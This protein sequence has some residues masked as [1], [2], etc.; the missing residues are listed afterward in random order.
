[1]AFCNIMNTQIEHITHLQCTAIFYNLLEKSLHKGREPI[2][3]AALASQPAAGHSLSF[4]YYYCFMTL[5]WGLL[6]EPAAESCSRIWLPRLRGF[7]TPAISPNKSKKL[8]WLIAP[9]HNIRCQVWMKNSMHCFTDNNLLSVQHIM[10]I[11]FKLC[12]VYC[13]PAL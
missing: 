5:G 4:Y 13:V 10:L 12:H 7:V 9:A 8:T 11:S 2:S 3:A 6:V 1:M